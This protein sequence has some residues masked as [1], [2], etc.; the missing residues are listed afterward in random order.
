MKRRKYGKPHNVLYLNHTGLP[1][2]AEFALARLLGAIDQTRVKPIVVFGD[3]GRAVELVKESNVETHVIPLTGEIRDM[4]KDTVGPKAFLNLK[5]AALMIAY[6]ARIAAFARQKNIQLIHTNTIKAHIYGAIAGRLAGLPVIWHV[7]DCVNET[8]FPPAAVK[9]LR[10]LARHAPRH[11]IG[12]SQS[13]MEQLRLNDGGGRSTVVLDGLSDGELD[14]SMNGSERPISQTIARIGIVGRL[15]R[16][17][18]Q[19]VF[20]EAAAKII[21]AGYDARFVIVGAAL[22]G[23]EAYEAELREQV[24]AL[25]IESRVE[26]LGFTR[27]VPMVLRNLDILVHASTMGEPFGQ[28][29]VEGMAA[30]KPVIATRGGGVPEIIT[31]GETGVLTAMGDPDELARQVIFLLQNPEVAARMGQA[32]F[33]HVRQN[34]KASC[35]ARKVEDL[36]QTLLGSEQM[37]FLGTLEDAV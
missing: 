32:G 11:V 35:G 28:V 18:G 27:A 16:W 30:G 34:F 3:H 12:V 9:V 13:V 6:A 1:G 29:I 22:F 21:N 37:D 23:E 31:N 19:H 20:L 25:N 14:G 15:A 7:R 10:F 8:Y 33:D 24:K 2:G 36:Y 5:Q 26:F 4:R 17:K